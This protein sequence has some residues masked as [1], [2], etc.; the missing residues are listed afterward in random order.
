MRQGLAAYEATGA[1]VGRPYFLALLAEVHGKG[2]QTAEGLLLSAEALELVH[3]TA[4][5]LWEAELHRLQGELLLAGSADQQRAAEAC[6]RQALNVARHQ[7]AKSLELRAAMSLCRLWPQH[8]QRQEAHVLLAELS[9]WFTEGE[10]TADVQEARG[11]LERWEGECD[12]R[13]SGRVQA[14]AAPR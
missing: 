11:L 8:G 5:G 2:G 4:E 1:A 3:T 6:F 13:P 12:H 9:G 7:H 14:C 10:E